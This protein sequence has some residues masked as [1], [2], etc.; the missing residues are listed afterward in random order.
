MKSAQK[1]QQCGLFRFFPP[2]LLDLL[3][4]ALLLS[5]NTVATIHW[6][7]PCETNVAQGH[8]QSHHTILRIAGSEY[9]LQHLLKPGASRRLSHDRD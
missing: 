9:D 2:P 7:V 6:H 3:K 8:L 4:A 5:A 1:A